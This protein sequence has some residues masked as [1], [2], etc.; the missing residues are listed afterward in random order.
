M[1][2][3]SDL[4]LKQLAD[5][6]QR[7]GNSTPERNE[8]TGKNITP[9][10]SELNPMMT[11]DGTPVKTETIGLV[12]SSSGKILIEDFDK[13]DSVKG[14]LEELREQLAQCHNDLE[15]SKFSNKL[16]K[17]ISCGR[18]GLKPTKKIKYIKKRKRKQTKKRKPTKNRKQNRKR[19]QTK[20]R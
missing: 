13:S 12:S 1:T 3:E 20:K 2:D 19:K 7:Y 15:Q 8:S 9:G 17:M 18:A 5:R 4:S 10:T 6:R 16:K 11:P 14:E